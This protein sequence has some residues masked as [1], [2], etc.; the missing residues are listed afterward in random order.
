LA[1]INTH[2][3]WPIYDYGKLHRGKD[4]GAG[5]FTPYHN[6]TTHASRYIPAGGELFKFYGNGYF[7]SRPKV[8]GYDFP[9]LHN[10]QDAEA[11]IRNMT[12]MNLPA[13]I[14][15]DLYESVVLA[16]QDV[17]TSRMMR[18]FPDSVTGAVVAAEQEIAVL[19]QPNATRSI[20]WLQEYGRCMDNM[21]PQFS[22]LFQAGRGAFATRRLTEGQVITTSPLLHLPF[23]SFVEMYDFEDYVDDATGK[24]LRRAMNVSGHQ[25]LTNYCYGHVKSSMVLCPYGNGINY[26]N[27]NQTLANVRIRWAEGFDIV[28]NQTLVENGTVN[29]LMWNY[30]PQLALDYI[31]LRDIKPGEELYLD[32]GNMWEAAWQ[33]HVANWKPVRGADKY[34]AGLD[35]N[36]QHG[37]VPIRTM[38]EQATNPYPE[39]LLIRAH[40]VLR[41]IAYVKEGQFQW[42]LL[43]FGYEARILERYVT[44]NEHYYTLEIGIPSEAVIQADEKSDGAFSNKEA[45]LTWYLREKVP[46]YAVAFFDKHGYTDI[47]LPNAFR[48]ILGIPDDIF[49]TKW[50]NAAGGELT[51]KPDSIA[52]D[53]ADTATAAGDKLSAT[54]PAKNK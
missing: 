21:S 22:N 11:L 32:Y 24:V 41:D 44:A 50:K 12:A 9:L 6:G 27:H 1:L 30:K 23:S 19:H 53:E 28:H 20:A 45:D 8:F 18:A 7:E 25:V 48:H 52:G 4:P 39:H 51:I 54:P 38:N 34:I 15:Q 43:D 16:F 14:Q 36:L 49:P 26:I 35:I 31:A 13:E 17:F 42:T 37:T 29:E 47:H 46:R 10:Y 33:R 2:R 5:A 3:S 40:R